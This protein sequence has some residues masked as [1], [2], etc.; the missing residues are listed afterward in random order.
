M[1]ILH[2]LFLFFNHAFHRHLN[3]S[4]RIRGIIIQRKE[5]LKM[6]LDASRPL[7]ISSLL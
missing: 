6:K 7:S 5:N 2:Y 1:G 4:D 3:G